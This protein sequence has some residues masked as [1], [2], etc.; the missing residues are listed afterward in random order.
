MSWDFLE[1]SDTKLAHE[2]FDEHGFANYVRGNVAEQRG[3]LLNGVR[4]RV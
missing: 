4:W 2:V 1:L 3:A